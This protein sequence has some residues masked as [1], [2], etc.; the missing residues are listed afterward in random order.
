MGFSNTKMQVLNRDMIKYIAMLT[1]LLNHIAHMFLPPGSVLTEIMTDIGY[2]TA[3]TMCYFMVEGYEYTR[4][5]AKYGLRLL[6]FAVLSQIPFTRAF[7][8]GQLNMMFT[9]LCCFL[10]L[11]VMEKVANPLLRM[12]L[13][14]IL[15]FATVMGDW[16]LFAP[17][18]TILFHNSKGDRKKMIGS[19][20]IT[21]AFF[22]LITI[23]SNLMKPGYTMA[24]AVVFGV[25]S[26]AG[27]VM[28]AVVVLF[29][30]NG[31]RA[32]KGKNFSKWFFYIFYPG[33]LVI[34]YF[35]RAL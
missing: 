26:A 20:G 12:L 18:F 9:L 21:C 22:V 33:H 8:T 29:F 16:P 1:M 11:A 4:S 3:P 14:M 31:K 15:M 6:A 19:Y 24:E 17:I 23:Q 13:A 27:I 7:E 34:L 28:S 32:E 30:Y 35:I 10:I 25:M 2:F 5:K